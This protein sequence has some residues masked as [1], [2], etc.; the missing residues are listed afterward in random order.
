MGKNGEKVSLTGF[1]AW[2]GLIEY[3]DRRGGVSF[4][5]AV[6]LATAAAIDAARNPRRPRT[7]ELSRVISAFPP[8]GSGQSV[9]VPW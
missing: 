7:M 5:A 2:T 8:S 6:G 4:A 1:Q 9:M 3:E